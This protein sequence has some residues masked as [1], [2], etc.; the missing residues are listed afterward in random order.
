MGGAVSHEPENFHDNSQ[1]DLW[2]RSATPCVADILWLASRNRRLDVP[3][4]LSWIGLVVAGGLS[5]F[6][7]R[8]AMRG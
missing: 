5:Y 6:G 2:S 8:L 3:M 7:I 1:R 4:W